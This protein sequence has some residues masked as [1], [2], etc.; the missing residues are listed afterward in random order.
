MC[1]GGCFLR[2]R[3]PVRSPQSPSGSD[4]PG[5]LLVLLL[6]QSHVHLTTRSFQKCTHAYSPWL[7]VSQDICPMLLSHQ[8]EHLQLVLCLTQTRR[9]EGYGP[10]Y[11]WPKGKENTSP[12]A[13]GPSLTPFLSPVRSALISQK[14]EAKREQANWR[15]NQDRNLRPPFPPSLPH[16]AAP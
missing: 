2:G 7:W 8:T 16:S 1:K 10:L 4:L 11:L 14:T 13:T 3:L 6:L 12:Q 9:Q 5:P 15:Q